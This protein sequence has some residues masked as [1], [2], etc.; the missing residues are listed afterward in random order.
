MSQLKLKSGILLGVLLLGGGA[1]GAS[2]LAK[3]LRMAKSENQT[4]YN[5]RTPGG[6][7]L[8]AATIQAAQDE[9]NCSNGSN[10]CATGTPVGGGA[11]VNLMKP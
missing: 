4:L 5:W 10:I 2:S 11:D 1:A 8:N 3:A 9:F 7:T 6:A